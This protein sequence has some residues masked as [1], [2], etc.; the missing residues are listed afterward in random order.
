[1]N[2][3]YFIAHKKNHIQTG[4]LSIDILFKSIVCMRQSDKSSQV[5]TFLAKMMRKNQQQQKCRSTPP[6]SQ[7]RPQYT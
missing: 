3:H 4:P 7:E 5:D 2:C 6:Y 1:M